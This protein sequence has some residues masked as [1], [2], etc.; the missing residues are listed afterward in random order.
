MRDLT[1]WL[2]QTGLPVSE[3][4]FAQ[5]P[6]VPYLVFSDAV[7]VTGGDLGPFYCSRTVVLALHGPELGSDGERAV[8]TLLMDESIP[9]E[10]S[11]VWLEAENH[12]QTTY[13]FILNEEMEDEIN[14]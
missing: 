9:Y 1:A 14:E 4:H 6:S 12:Y 11:R 8:E 10:R 5:T 13:Q 7:S 2:S 3:L